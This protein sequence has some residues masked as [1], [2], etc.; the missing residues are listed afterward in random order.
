MPP[1][2]WYEQMR[3][4]PAEFLLA[5]FRQQQEAVLEEQTSP[6][7]NALLDSN[8]AKAAGNNGSFQLPTIAEKIWIGLRAYT[9]MIYRMCNIDKSAAW[10][11][12]VSNQEWS[13]LS[14][15]MK[16]KVFI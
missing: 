12:L 13:I 6:Q 15:C 16:V 10:L 11:Q 2:Q 5:E 7:D 1:A 3:T 14:E 8:E 4:P 9:R